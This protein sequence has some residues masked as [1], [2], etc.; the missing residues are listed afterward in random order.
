MK[1]IDELK[2]YDQGKIGSCTANSIAQAL[3]IKSDNKISIS[4]LFMYFNSRLEEG[5]YQSDSGANIL[6]CMKALLKYKYIE[7]ALYPYDISKF[8][9]FPTPSIYVEA[10]K[11]KITSYHEVT[12]DLYH[13]KSC[14]S[15]YL[16]PINFGALL[17]DNFENVDETGGMCSNS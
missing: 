14:L 2:I 3:Q 16:Q 5:T 17:Y 13:I 15:Q 9:Q 6:D 7:E 4:R 1:P 10:S 12:Q 11:N 8:A